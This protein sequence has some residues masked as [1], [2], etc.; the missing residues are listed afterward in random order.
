MKEFVISEAKSETAVLVGLTTKNQDE[1][2]TK[3]Y[4]D[5]L[6]FLADTAGAVTVKRFTQKVAGPNS[7]TYIGTGKLE[8][9]RQFIKDK[10]DEGNE[11]GMVI[12]DDELS[13]KQLRNIEKCLQVKILDRT[14]L[15]LDIFAMR[16]QTAEAKTQVELAQHRYMLPRLQRL[17]T[18]LERQGGGSGSGGGKGSVGLRGPG[19]TQLEM[20]RRIIL[21]RI[22]LLKQRLLEIDKQKTTQR[23]NRGRLIREALV[24]YTNVGT[25]TLMN[26]LSKSEVF[27]ENKLFATLDTTVR[28]MV[29]DNLPFLLADTVGF[30]RKLP[31]D[32]V[33]S[34][35]S[36]LDEVREADLL[37]HVVDISHPDFEEQIKVVDKTLQE[38][39][40]ADKPSMIVFNKIDAY[41][42][43]DKEPDDLTPITKENISLD[44]LRKTWMAKMGDCCIFISAR[45]KEN[46]DELRDI[47]YMKVRELHVQKYPY[48]DFL[49]DNFE[50]G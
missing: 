45:E 27:A 40:C 28:K 48:N 26:L 6:E 20:D 13:A 11:V 35:K 33:D 43:V 7:V 19:E 14:S 17:W 30:I 5:E 37:L 36:T 44:E 24:G 21:Q 22:T 42:W 49:Y 38:L 15:I 39:G 46:I 8:E 10:E 31:T 23:K 32:L 2:K 29:I 9:I 41:T 1:A 4:L 47:L 12:F 25:S 3:E 34:F 50:Q 18:H 16:A